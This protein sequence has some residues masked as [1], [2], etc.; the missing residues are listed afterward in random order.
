M[1]IVDS[2][3]DRKPSGNL[4]FLKAELLFKTKKNHAAVEL[5]S[6]NLKAFKRKQ[7]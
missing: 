6:S 5:I 2:N 3:L 7:G 1:E 4:I